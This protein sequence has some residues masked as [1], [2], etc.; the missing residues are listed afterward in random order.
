MLY[1]VEFSIFFCKRKRLFAYI[2]ST[3]FA[4][5]VLGKGY[6]QSPATKA[7]FQNALVITL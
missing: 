4:P 1:F 2:A 5:C 7:D 3:Y 6:T